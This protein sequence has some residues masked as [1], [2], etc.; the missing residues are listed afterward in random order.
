MAAELGTLIQIQLPDYLQGHQVALQD[1]DFGIEI[2][3][4]INVVGVG[5]RVFEGNQVR[6]RFVD[7]DASYGIVDGSL[8]QAG[9]RDR[10][11]DAYDHRDHQ[12]LALDENA[13]VLAQHG[14][15]RREDV[16]ERRSDGAQKFYR[17]AGRLSARCFVT[18]RYI[19]SRIV[20]SWIVISWNQGSQ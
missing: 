7:G 16:I 3:L 1:A 5:R 9:N 17:F 2:A 18:E 12:P 6:I 15:L 10:H 14:F 13:H 19:P 8:A 11:E 20:I 4:L